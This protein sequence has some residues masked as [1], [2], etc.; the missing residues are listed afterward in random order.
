MQLRQVMHMYD[1]PSLSS[2]QFHSHIHLHHLPEGFST[3]SNNIFLFG[4]S[5]NVVIAYFQ[6]VN[7]RSIHLSKL[8]IRLFVQQSKSSSLAH[9]HTCIWIYEYLE[10]TLMRFGFRVYH[11]N[12]HW[13]GYSFF[14]YQPHAH[15]CGLSI[16]CW[17]WCLDVSAN[18]VHATT[19]TNG[20][21]L[22]DGWRIPNDDIQ[23]MLWSCF[24][25]FSASLP[26]LKFRISFHYFLHNLWQTTLHCSRS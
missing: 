4:I 18:F 16:G 5:V 23:L 20:S 1:Q 26:P 21:Y 17:C 12:M 25:R 22:R 19:G 13:H 8:S 9:S 11:K 7:R 3:S 15:Y 24:C 10:N 6:H 2:V 14:T